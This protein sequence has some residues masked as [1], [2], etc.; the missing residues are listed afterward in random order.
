MFIISI[1]VNLLSQSGNGSNTK[2]RIVFYNLENFFD[3]YVDS[4]LSYNEFTPQGDLHWTMNK[5]KQKAINTY[6]VFQAISGWDGITLAGVCE[7][8]SK[9]VLNQLLY[10][11]PLNAMSYRYIHYD[12]PDMRGIDVALIYGK[13]F[14]PLHSQVYSIRDDNGLEIGT[15]DILYVKGL[16]SDD[17]IHVFVNHWTSRYRGLLESNSLRYKFSKLLKLKTDSI[18]DLISNANIIVMGDF[19]DQS[20]DKSLIHLTNDYRLINMN[21]TPIENNSGGTL[22]FKSDWYIFDHILISNSFKS[23]EN[24]LMVSDD[25]LLIFDKLFLLEEDERY[26]GYKPYRTNLGYKYHGGYSDHLPIYFD[27]IKR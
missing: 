11:T 14:K 2:F 10:N 3:T 19:N 12:S 23:K 15:R 21:P 27:L 1:N 7:V 25:G 6:K 26:L 9:S 16:L 17:T 13:P 8:E 5:F 24:S 18:Q 20:H 4:T 22:K